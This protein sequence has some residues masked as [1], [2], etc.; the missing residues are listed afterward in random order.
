[1][2]I[3]QKTIYKIKFLYCRS[4]NLTAKQFE[5]TPPT[6]IIIVIKFYFIIEIYSLCKNVQ[7]N[8]QAQVKNKIIY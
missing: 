8:F 2:V 4:N 3:W 1:M 7:V 6:I 5:K